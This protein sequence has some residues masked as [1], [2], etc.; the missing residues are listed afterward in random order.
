MQTHASYA[1]WWMVGETG[2]GKSRFIH[3]KWEQWSRDNNAPVF[4]LDM[5]KM[6]PN[7]S[8]PLIIPGNTTG[9][10]VPPRRGD[11]SSDGPYFEFVNRW[12]AYLFGLAE[13]G[14]IGPFMLV[15]DETNT[16]IKRGYAPPGLVRVIMEGRGH[17]ISYMLGTRRWVE[18]PP[19]VRSEVDEIAL[20]NQFDKRDVDFA[21][22]KGIDKQELR[23]LEVG[24]WFHIQRRKPTH[25]HVG[26]C[27]PC[28]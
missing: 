10:V 13:N 24:E 22:E 12:C 17:D 15:I 6:L 1:R 2:A 14:D 16:A 27:S 20:F 9:R 8:L 11:L 21:T 25:K 3:L 19:D 5:R 7:P 28:D 23:A 26:A 4:V 18:C